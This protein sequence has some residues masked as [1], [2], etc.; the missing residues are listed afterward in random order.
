MIRQ[1]RRSAHDVSVGISNFLK[2]LPKAVK[3]TYSEIP[4]SLRSFKF[5]AYSFR[6]KLTIALFFGLILASFFLSDYY[7]SGILIT[8]MIYA[9]FAASWDLLA[10]YAGQVSFGQSVFFGLSGY[11]TAAFFCF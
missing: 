3:N 9:I 5:W 10:G 8:A 7:I 6:G 4:S 2:W 11:F 1:I